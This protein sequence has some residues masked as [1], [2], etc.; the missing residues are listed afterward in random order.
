[1]EFLYLVAALVTAGASLASGLTNLSASFYKEREKKDLIFGIMSLSLLVSLLLPPIGFVSDT[2]TSFQWQMGAKTFFYCGFYAL[3]PWFVQF[4]TTQRKRLIPVIID[5]LG[6]TYFVACLTKGSSFWLASLFLGSNLAYGLYVALAQLNSDGKQKRRLL[7]LVFGLFAIFFSLFVANQFSGRYLETITGV[8]PFSPLNFFPVSF[9]IIMG[10]YLR[11]RS[12][13]KFTSEKM[14]R[15]RDT[16]RSSLMENMKLL[17]VELD[18]LGQI[19]YLNEYA[20]NVLGQ[21]SSSEFIGRNWFDAFSPREEAEKNKSEYLQKIRKRDLVHLGNKIATRDGRELL[22]NWSDDLTHDDESKINGSIHLGLVIEDKD[23]IFEGIEHVK[24][25]GQE[26]LL[27]DEDRSTEEE[28]DMV[29]HSQAF[30]YAIQKARQVAPTN[31][32][33][34]LEGET[35]VGKELFADLIHRYSYRK[36]KPFIKI[37]CA[38]LPPELIESELFG[39]EK[40]AFTGALQARK[41]RFELAHGGAIFLDEVG[42][43]PLHLQPK[44]LRVL[45]NGEFERIGGQ[46]TIK[47]DV[48]VIS[49]TNR[50][51]LSEVQ[52]SRFREDL[53]YR[54]NVFPITIPPLRN[55]REDIPSLVKHFVNKFSK[56]HNRQIASIAKQDMVRLIEHPWPGNIREL[57]NVVERSV[58][59]SQG[60]ALKLD[61]LS[62]FPSTESSSFPSSATYIEQVERA[63]I[64]KV[65]NECSWKISGDDG[66]AMKL[67]L[68]PSTLRSRLKKLNITRSEA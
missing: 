56:E 37:N 4:V 22:I 38:A 17:I 15:R 10:I 21:Q 59:S 20:T 60:D 30:I 19:K 5:A 36:N 27:L 49:A 47:V 58:I 61:S 14:L 33:V 63:H 18:K 54:L 50:N 68:N 12:A 7:F 1:M 39:H 42:E 3:L 62:A 53:Y 44:L 48:R 52:R 51:L 26:Y 46:E 65:L 6:V 13:D 11:F 23:K 43:L 31:A 55:R 64:V 24:S 8:S 32:I 41:G 28:P 9:L 35:G 57:V 25:I 16:R 45:E 67:G 40:G 66:A 34:L 29:G 2:T